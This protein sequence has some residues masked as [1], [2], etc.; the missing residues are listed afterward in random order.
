MVTGAFY[1]VFKMGLYRVGP[2]EVLGLSFS[3][4]SLV[5]ENLGADFVISET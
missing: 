2:G 1:F 3:R 4:I 5:N